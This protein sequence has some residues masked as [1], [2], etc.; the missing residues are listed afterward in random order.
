MWLG[1]WWGSVWK[2]DGGRLAQ[3]HRNEFEE[4]V[5]CRFSD[6][7]LRQGVA[8]KLL[9]EGML[10]VDQNGHDNRGVADL[11]LGQVWTAGKSESGS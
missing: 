11:E 6:G 4:R 1:A 9:Y 3:T 5:D 10:F 2:I 8:C 7:V